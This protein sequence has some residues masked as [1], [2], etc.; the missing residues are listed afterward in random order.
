M[1]LKAKFM[2][3]FRE[4]V[5]I[6]KKIS[7]GL[8][9]FMI[10]LSSL[11]PVVNANDFQSNSDTTKAVTR[12]AIPAPT[13]NKVFYDATTI[14]GAKLHGDRVGEKQVADKVKDLGG[15]DPVAIKKWVGDEVDWKN[16]VKAKVDT[17]KD[18]VKELLKGATFEDVTEKKRSTSKEGD[19]EGK[20]KVTF[21]D[22]SELVVEKQM[23]YVSNLVTSEKR[24][25]TPDDAL[26]V[27]FKLGEGTKV[28]NT[29]GTSINGN[30]DNPVSYQKYKVKPNTNLKTYKYQ[31]LNETY[32]NLI[33]SNVK[34]IDKYTEPVWNDKNGL[35]TKNFTITE[36]NKVFTAKAT[37]TYDITFDANTG[38]GTKEKVTQKV[39]TEYELPAANTF[40]APE[41]KQFSGWQ[42]GKD[43]TLKQPGTKIKITG[44]T[45]IKASWKPIMVEKTKAD[46][47]DAL[48]GLDPVVLKKWV[49]DKVDW[50]KGVKA[51][52][53]TKETEVKE[54]LKGATFE[55][56]TVEKRSTSK[57]GDFEGKIKITFDD[58]SELAVEKQML[59]VSNLV[60]SEKRENTPDDALV[61]EFKLGEGTKVNNTNGTSIN[62]NKDNPVSYE[63][64]KVKPNTDLK[65]YTLPVV[66][67]SVVDSIILSAQ[68]GYTDP[69]WNTNSF[70]ATTT[71][72]VFTATA[73]KTF[74]VTVKAN[75]GTG[76]DKV[77]IK[78]K[79]ET[80]KLPA[81]NTFTPPNENQEFSGWQVG[82]DTK[83]L[84]K[85]GDEIKITG[86]T[87]VKAIWKPIEFKV[88]FKAGEGASGAMPDVPVTKG[89]E[90]ELPEPTF[91]AP[92][93]Q[94]FAGWKVGDQEGVKQAKERIT[95]TGNVTLTATWK[96][97][98]VDVSFDKGEGSGNKDKVSVA[99]GS[100][101]TLPNSDGFTAPPGKEFAGWK[102]GNK[103]GVKQAGETIKITDNET[104]TATWKD[105]MVNVSYNAN[106][107]SG[108]M[109]GKE[110]KKGSTLTLPS[111]SFTAPAGKEFAGWLVGDATTTTEA[112]TEITITGDTIIKASWK[113]IMVDVSF[114][115]GEGSGSKDKVSVAKGSEYTL[116]DS[117]GFT[118]PAGKEFA[119][120]EVNGEAKKVGDKITVTDNTRVTAKYKQI[121]ESGTKDK[122]P[123]TSVNPSEP[124]SKDKKPSTGRIDGKDRIETAINIS[125][126]YYDRA[127]TVIVVRHDLF[128]DSMTASVLAKL[129]DAPILLNPTAKLDPRVGAE[130]KRLG[131]EEVIIVGGQNSVSEK[132]REELKAYDV[133]KNVERIS[134]VD[135]YGTSEMVARRVVGI[136]GKKKTA[137]VAS[138]QV[139]PDALSV[140][141]FAS[142]EAYPIL[143][144][145]KD[146]VPA[147]I[148]KAIKD[149]DINKTYIA[150]GI[151]TISKATEAKLPGVLERMAGQ[152]RYETSVAI[153]K[154][155]FKDSKEAFLASGE[156]FA[157]ALV[158]SPISG[159]YNRPTL[160]VSRKASNNAPVKAYVKDSRLTSITAI[161]G[162][163]YIPYSVLEDL[164]K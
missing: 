50:K 35:V 5:N 65:T 77:E 40:T 154:S 66:N 125:K 147:Q 164:V 115:K 132:V 41:N 37:K 30:K 139:F 56:V 45:V 117:K 61:V 133:D 52:N 85:A 2:N 63:K 10:T 141:T 158:I 163:K 151:N 155:K 9:S 7:V 91:T 122:K 138:G 149:L 3:L 8:L 83:N 84:K 71:N 12:G 62:G 129:K 67:A 135:R 90:Y 94:E 96:P 33:N 95:I 134:G 81:A 159:K 146:S 145:K 127:K 1:N 124:G 43:T 76:D 18:E 88:Y 128:P 60:T 26:V 21:D 120:W 48:G 118:A 100:D 153:A 14:S 64:Y 121:S 49:G 161:G 20:I 101:Y 16:G 160:L 89:S 25:N 116:P 6:S 70:V 156:E 22:K 123:G 38:G 13:I 53:S 162:Q 73:T 75:G 42:V 72:N 106:G 136:A 78:K 46:K 157:D 102:V 119:G 4:N 79:D 126:K 17:K 28:N 87:E 148:T 74:K 99:K 58:K 31:T 11:T 109:E 32:Y 93:N 111:N 131:A 57:E 19:F 55:D 150:G 113:P 15:L 114:D 112:G 107:G 104:L 36:S 144:V 110:L 142:R 103:D 51:K 140:G 69:T 97:I 39:N 44:D 130:I 29:D 68:D 54:L 47:V 98:M 34:T 92:K 108:K 152:T 137:V 80:F 23:L 86:D 82:D 105:I 27:E 143:L 59:Y 24:E